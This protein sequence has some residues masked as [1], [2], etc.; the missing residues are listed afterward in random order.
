MNKAKAGNGTS[1]LPQKSLEA[2]KNHQDR[3]GPGMLWTSQFCPLNRSPVLSDCI[4]RTVL[5][6]GTLW[7]PTST[8]VDSSGIKQLWEQNAIIYTK[9]IFNKV[10]HTHFNIIIIIIIMI[11]IIKIIFRECFS[12]ASIKLAALYKPLT[13]K[14]VQ[15][16]FNKAES[17][18]LAIKT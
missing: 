12:L 17:F 13:M 11:I 8:V 3:N 6:Q 15:K 16:H 2:R 10:K 5:A 4:I 1:N 7:I 18:P 14:T 9:E